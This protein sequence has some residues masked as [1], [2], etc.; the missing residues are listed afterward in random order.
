[1]LLRSWGGLTTVFRWF[2]QSTLSIC[3]IFKNHIVL[4]WHK[5]IS[6]G[7]KSPTCN[8]HLDLFYFLISYF[9]S[10]P[11]S[12][13]CKEV[14]TEWL[15][16]EPVPAEDQEAAHLEKK[17]GEEKGDDSEMMV[18]KK[19]TLNSASSGERTDQHLILVGFSG[20]VSCLW[21]FIHNHVNNY[22]WKMFVL[23]VPV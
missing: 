22:S 7:S 6:C 8:K 19:P 21:L 13:T 17:R 15:L 4:C 9:C 12:F 16:N 23:N 11:S 1:M 10:P 20:L 14:E 18:Q 2:H 5:N 3:K